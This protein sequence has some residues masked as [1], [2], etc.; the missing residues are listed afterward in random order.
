M[1]PQHKWLFSAHFRRQ[2][3]GWR[4]DT[5]IQRIKEAVAEIK[6]V[7]RK[8]PEIAAEGA[9][10]LLE[11]L[12]PALMQVD[13]SS[14]A[15]GAAVNHAIEALAPI[16]SKP[17]VS[18]A[19]RQKWLERLWEAMQED[20]T[21]YIELLGNYWG[22][23]CATPALASDWAN[24][25]LPVIELTWRPSESGHGYFKGTSACFSAL[26]AAG[27]YDELFT[28]LGKAPYAY[29]PYRRWGV[30]AMAAL[31]KPA[32]ALQYAEAS[33]GLNQPSGQ[34]TETCESILLAAGMHNE[35]Y[36]RYAL[37]ANQRGT[38]LATFRAIIK[39]YPNKPPA[40]I[41]NDL[42]AST[43]GTE[44]KWFTAAKDAKLFEVAA[45]LIQRSPADPH[46]LIRAALDF[47][48]AKPD[49]AY[50]CAMSALHWISLDYAYEITAAEVLSVYSIA[51]KTAGS[52]GVE[53]HQ[54]VERIRAI[55]AGQQ[56]AQL[57]M[58][59]VLQR[60]LPT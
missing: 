39:K 17:D 49:F 46:T 3:Y 31:G 19:I 16:I 13:S 26:Y 23:V 1:T 58:K 12:S 57:F 51:L 44:G 7:A 4:S 15:L 14:G 29:W 52:C 10:K 11:K 18:S 41:L 5:P 37:T 2:A 8:Q 30:K 22:E 35:A 27:R 47:V 54:L 43:P 53:Q 24:I 59:K 48:A 25:F 40:D 55:I 9:V 60:Y 38:Y 21:P 56:P 6:Q 33:H 50:A 34:I 20:E 28:L 32:E 45:K 36:Q 42:I